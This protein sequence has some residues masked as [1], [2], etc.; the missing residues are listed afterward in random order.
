MTCSAFGDV[1]E[2]QACP[3]QLQGWLSCSSM[4]TLH[5]ETSLCLSFVWCCKA[6]RILARAVDFHC[7]LSM[8][9]L[10]G[11]LMKNGDHFRP[12]CSFQILLLGTTFIKGRKKETGGFFCV[13]SLGLI[14]FCANFYANLGK[15]ICSFYNLFIPCVILSSQPSI[16]TIVCGEEVRIYTFVF[17]GFWSGISLMFW[18]EALYSSHTT[19]LSPIL[20]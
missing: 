3:G 15:C 9:S 7:E 6:G 20:Y 18:D 4:A 16:V 10:N 11:V 5:T 1:R 13:F 19:A 17:L 14:F 2:S 12:H 8:V